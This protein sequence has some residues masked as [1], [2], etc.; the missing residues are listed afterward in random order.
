MD[1]QAAGSN[2]GYPPFIDGG[3][4]RYPQFDG[5]Q[6]QTII[7][8]DLGTKLRLGDRQRMQ[9]GIYDRE[10]HALAESLDGH[11]HPDHC[12]ICDRR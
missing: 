6:S 5:P 8:P 9:I 1:T 10:P 7:D 3:T 11:R 4:W 12:R 2:G